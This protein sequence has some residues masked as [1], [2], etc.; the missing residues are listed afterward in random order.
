MKELVSKK[1]VSLV[2][3]AVN[4]LAGV[5]NGVCPTTLSQSSFFSENCPVDVFIS[6]YIPSM[7]SLSKKCGTLPFVMTRERGG[8]FEIFSKRGISDF[9]H[10]VVGLVK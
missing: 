8:V 9:S 1:A 3:F 6:I 2:T 5:L 10:R 4:Y 7:K